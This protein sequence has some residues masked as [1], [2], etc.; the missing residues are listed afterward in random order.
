MVKLVYLGEYLIRI[1]DREYLFSI[2][3]NRIS[4][5]NV[6]IIAIGFTTGD[7]STC[8]EQ[9]ATAWK[10]KVVSSFSARYC[11]RSLFP[12]SRCSGS[13]ASKLEH[14]SCAQDAGCLG[15]V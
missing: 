11:P 13:R 12:L 15:K 4:M 2:K 14:H 9:G 10:R 7:A 5:F 6:C 1:P 3:L 8:Y